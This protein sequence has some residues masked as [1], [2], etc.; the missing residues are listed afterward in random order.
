MATACGDEPLPTDG[1]LEGTRLALSLVEHV[2][3]SLQ[4]TAPYRCARMPARLEAPVI[5]DMPL[6]VTDAVVSIEKL[7]AKKTLL[8]AALADARGSE[9][10]T[11]RALGTMREKLIK[12]KVDVV[13]SLG[14]MG[15]TED[16]IQA[17]LGELSREAPYLLVAIPGDRESVAAHRQAVRT[18]AD[19]GARV[20]DGATYRFLRLGGVLLA[21]MPGIAMTANLVAGHEGCEHTGDDVEALLD[22]LSNEKETVLLASYSPMR[23]QGKQASDQGVGAIHTGEA[24]LAPLL[25]SDA[26]SLV[27]HGMVQP[28][29]P[30]ARGKIR[31]GQGTASLATGSLD[32]LEGPSAALLLS[33]AGKRVTWRRVGARPQ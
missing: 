13:I 1:Q 6:T 2:S 33:I 9:A 28:E 31:P 12:E 11:L 5:P 8:I 14:G 20:L 3:T 27:I 23:G 30:A 4:L 18:L 24:L 22:L 29:A 10:E 25:D 32:P 15:E 26:L 17:V 19:S 7:A 21:T 16:A